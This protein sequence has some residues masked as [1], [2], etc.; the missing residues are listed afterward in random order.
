[1]DHQEQHHLYHQKEREHEKKEQRKYECAR[2]REGTPVHPAWLFAVGIELV[3]GAVL[4]WLLL[5]L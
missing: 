4:V 1:M 2:E 5:V 3:L